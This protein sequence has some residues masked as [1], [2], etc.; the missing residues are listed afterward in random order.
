[1]RARQDSPLR[2]FLPDADPSRGPFGV[3]GVSPH[4]CDS[5]TVLEA[6]R[7]SLERIARHPEARTPDAEEVR[8]ALHVAAAQ[9][10]DA[11]TRAAMIDM[12]T[13]GQTPASAT[14]TIAPSHPAPSDRGSSID[15]FRLACFEMIAHSGGWNARARRR[16]IALADVFG[17]EPQELHTVFQ[18]APAPPRATA[19][20][21]RHAAPSSAPQTPAAIASTPTPVPARR[22]AWGTATLVILNLLAALALVR[23]IWPSHPA[24]KAKQSATKDTQ[25]INRPLTE[26]ADTLDPITTVPQD[27]RDILGALRAL[28]DQ[29]RDTPV[30]TRSDALRSLSERLASTWPDL[31]P[32]DAELIVQTFDEIIFAIASASPTELERLADHWAQRLTAADP[33]H[34]EHAWVIAAAARLASAPPLNEPARNRFATM[35]ADQ[36]ITAAPDQSAT[37]RSSLETGLHHA[38]M[39]IANGLV[40]DPLRAG[41]FSEAWARWLT[42]TER[43]SQWEPHR[44]T[45]MLDT[46]ESLAL[47]QPG[48]STAILIQAAME[49]TIAAVDWRNDAA[50]LRLMAWLADDNALPAPAL[51]IAT[52]QIVRQRRDL[53]NTADLLASPSATGQSRQ[54]L[55]AEWSRAL[56]MG[57]PEPRRRELGAWN[58]LLYE[59]SKSL[60]NAQSTTDWMIA[61]VRH[62]RANTAAELLWRQDSTAAA[63]LMRENDWRP[64]YAAERNAAHPATLAELTRPAGEREAEWSERF[65]N[66]RND[67]NERMTLLQEL[68]RRERLRSQTDAD[69]LADAAF[70]DASLQVR[71]SAQQVVRVFAADPRMVYAALESL[72]R[73]GRSSGES[74]MVE[75]LTDRRLPPARHPEWH[76]RAA[77]ALLTRLMEL[78]ARSTSTIPDQAAIELSRLYNLRSRQTDAHTDAD[79]DPSPIDSITTSGVELLT[80]T[81]PPYTIAE[82]LEQALRREASIIAPAGQLLAHDDLQ[83][84]RRR[85]TSNEIERFAVAQLSCFELLAMITQGE[86]SSRAQAI[87]AIENELADA[88]RTATSLSEQLARTEAATAKVWAI[89]LGVEVLQ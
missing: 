20:V 78:S 66:A 60:S 4:Q 58:S 70:Y 89:R 51:A 85:L 14:P 41:T 29:A 45:V 42:D 67:P 10:L 13:R 9:L 71:Q 34:R 39:A 59:A 57:T 18:P 19:P 54:A 86:R 15:A 33:A 36:S 80:A 47:L 2:R 49:R 32:R 27:S 72:P 26:H 48:Q 52:S 40:N 61:T 87:T 35:L 73:T 77:A 5:E 62:A 84:A 22:I 23:V 25:A 7:R 50:I 16:V 46:F 53:T 63:P 81:E 28:R 11:D 82:R 43:V 55:Q 75:S 38:G 30:S 88:R 24:D 12:W 37:A 79:G 1:M 8:L 64:D 44:F 17:I 74:E 69:V 56:N 76:A 65:L 6:L 68:R 83:S 21:P 3:L 31:P